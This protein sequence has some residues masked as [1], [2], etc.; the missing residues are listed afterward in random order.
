MHRFPGARIIE[1]QQTPGSYVHY[2]VQYEN[3]EPETINVKRRWEGHLPVTAEGHPFVAIETV[4]RKTPRF[5]DWIPGWTIDRSITTID[6]VMYTFPASVTD[7]TYFFPYRTLCAVTLVNLE[8]WRRLF[9]E[10]ET[11][12]RR[13]DGGFDRS[14]VI[15]VPGNVVQA[16]ISKFDPLEVSVF[17]CRP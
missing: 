9:G 5:A 4:S 13:V 10:K 12:T 7:R 8:A 11:R 15:F 2:I 6:W 16:A 3:S 14:S 1:P 17:F